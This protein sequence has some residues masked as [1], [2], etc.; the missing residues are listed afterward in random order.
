MWLVLR[1]LHLYSVCSTF[2]SCIV[3]S[4]WHGFFME[5]L[6]FLFVFDLTSLQMMCFSQNPDGHVETVPAQKRPFWTLTN[7]KDRGISSWVFEIWFLSRGWRPYRGGQFQWHYKQCDGSG[8]RGWCAPRW[9]RRT[10]GCEIW[11]W[12]R[13]F[14]SIQFLDPRNCWWKKFCT[15]WE[16]GM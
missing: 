16:V 11:Q 15:T 5:S 2:P 12:R 7:W 3:F 10:V 8:R 14:D 13:V 9:W 1:C 6:C 4:N